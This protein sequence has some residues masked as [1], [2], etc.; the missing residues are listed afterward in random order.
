MEFFYFTYGTDP[1]YPF[2]GGYTLIFADNVKEAIKLFRKRH[3]DRHEGVVNCAFIYTADEFEEAFKKTTIE[4]REVIFQKAIKREDLKFGYNIREISVL[5]NI[6]SKT[7]QMI[8]KMAGLPLMLK[9]AEIPFMLSQSECDY[10][11]QETGCLKFS[12]DDVQYIS[13]LN[14]NREY[15]ENQSTIESM[16]RTMRTMANIENLEESRN[17]YVSNVKPL[18]DRNKEIMDE[19]KGKYPNRIHHK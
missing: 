6:I 8:I 10:V 5:C 4:C 9:K 14:F 17:Y 18:L 16:L 13:E 2:E 12:P 7:N 11:A 15:R 1:G 19:I 3:P